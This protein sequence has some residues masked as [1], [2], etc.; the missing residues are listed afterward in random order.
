MEFLCIVIERLFWLVII[1]IDI[2]IFGMVYRVVRCYDRWDD[3]VEVRI[4][5]VICL[6]IYRVKNKSF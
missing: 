2:K 4:N 1:S 3:M 6:G 5:K